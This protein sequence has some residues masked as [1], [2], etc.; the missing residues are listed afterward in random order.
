LNDLTALGANLGLGSASTLEEEEVK[1][2]VEVV[3]EVIEVNNH[4]ATQIVTTTGNLG[5]W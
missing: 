5:T 2:V 4:I 3:M 1:E